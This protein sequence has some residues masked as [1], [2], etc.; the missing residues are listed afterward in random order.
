MVAGNM[1]AQATLYNAKAEPLF[2]FGAAPRNTI[3]WSPH[4]RFLC[5]AGFGNLAGEMDFYDILRLKKI[6]SNVSDCST[7]YS[8][9]PDS[10][11][12]LTASLAPRMNVDNNMR[13]FRYNGDGPLLKMDFD[14]AYE[15]IWMPVLAGTVYPNR[16]PSPG[17]SQVSQLERE[18]RAKVVA[19]KAAA[20]PAPYRPPRSTGAVASMLTRDT[21]APVGKVK[22]APA[23]T[24]A[25]AP[26]SGAT[27][28]FV[29][30]AKSRVIPGMA[31]KP[32]AGNAAPQA[33]AAPSSAAANNN[34]PA[35]QPAPA[36]NK[37]V[38]KPAATPAPAPAPAA[39]AAETPADREKRVKALQKKLKQIEEIKARIA[40]GQSV[41]P[42]Q[43]RPVHTAL[44]SFPSCLTCVCSLTDEES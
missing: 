18:E 7:R 33:K 15:A 8:W 23:A 38:T 19:A 34:R 42:E 10:R 24:A 5:L 2:Q 30:S 28:K 6:G 4:G 32:G 9:S 29:P 17:R 43:V 21:S 37:P 36:N 14:R 44:K 13:V 1:P 27:G 31:P 16:G 41:E 35:P 39:P 20:K 40:A 22:A 11:Y 25:P 3:V 12:F 26:S